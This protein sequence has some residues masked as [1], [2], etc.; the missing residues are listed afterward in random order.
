[1]FV[2]VGKFYILGLTFVGYCRWEKSLSGLIVNY[3][4]HFT[5]TFW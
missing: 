2:I 5:H 3:F 4:V 1:M